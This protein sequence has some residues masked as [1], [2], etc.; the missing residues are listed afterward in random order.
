MRIY[1]LFLLLIPLSGFGQT[2]EL[3]SLTTAANTSIR[4]ISVISDSVAWVSGSNGTIGLTT[5]GGKRWKWTK[6]KGYEKLD[7][8]DI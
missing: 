7:F 4:G 3:G 5:D 2:Y 6:P 1:L 8:R